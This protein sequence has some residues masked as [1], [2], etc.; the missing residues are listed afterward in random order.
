MTV[1]VNNLLVSGNIEASG[2]I[3]AGAKLGDFEIIDTR[4]KSRDKM[5]VATTEE[6]L[7]IR[8]C[9]SDNYECILH[10]WLVF[11][12]QGN[13]CNPLNPIPLNHQL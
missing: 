3:V 2:H 11:A 13:C 1:S 5:Y 9:D 7:R 6:S 8:L 12:G 4:E 10:L